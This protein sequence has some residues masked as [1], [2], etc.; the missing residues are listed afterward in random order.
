M[1]RNTICGAGGRTATTPWCD[2]GWPSSRLT[3]AYPSATETRASTYFPVQE[4]TLASAFLPRERSHVDNVR[5]RRHTYW[6]HVDE[7]EGTGQ[8]VYGT[9][10]KAHWQEGARPESGLDQYRK[11]KL[12]G[13]L[14]RRPCSQDGCCS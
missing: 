5:D 8:R 6:S 10:Q 9:A 3:P 11:T 13:V 2:V 7:Q 4:S 1:E 12:G 14:S